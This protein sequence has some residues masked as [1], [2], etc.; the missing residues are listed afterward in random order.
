MLEMVERGAHDYDRWEQQVARTGYCSK[1][2]R[3]AGKVQQVDR[4]TGEIRT[5]FDSEGE[6][7]NTLLIACGDRRESRCPSCAARYRGDAFHIVASG[8]KGGKGVPESVT[9]HPSLFVTFTAPSFG[10]VHAHRS[11]GRV[12]H[13][14]RPRRAG[15]CPHGQPLACWQRHE[16]GDPRVG[17]PL[18]PRCF[19]YEGQ[20]LWNNRLPE[21]WSRTPLAIRRA[22]AELTS[23]TTREVEKTIKLSFAKSA[24][25]QRRG[26]LH[27]HV[28]MR[29]D[30]VAQG[31]HFAP[32]P[33][34]FTS[35]AFVEAVQRAAPHV[36]VACPMPGEGSAQVRW[37]EQLE[38]RVIEGSAETSREAVSAYIA[39]YSTKSVEAFGVMEPDELRQ[40]EAGHL[41]RLKTVTEDLS[42][43]PELRHLGLARGVDQVGFKGHWT[44]KS[45]SY[46]TT[47]GALR[48]A[49]RMHV[50]RKRVP[51]GV[52]LDAWGR[53]EE[54]DQAMTYGVWRYV[55]CGYRNAGEAFL[56]SSAAAR[57]R[58]KRRV[59]ME[60][61]RSLPR[62]APAKAPVDAGR[63]PSNSEA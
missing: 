26:A 40:E 36:R 4:T 28:V 9:A 30:G 2:V 35:E 51:H 60:E 52:P 17:Q 8:L 43:L 27:F 61:L 31:E 63:S 24:E 58:E 62:I 45:R 57:A 53:P 20:V 56:A 49:R 39:K 23:M 22:L 33:E 15:K 48:A 38:V 46:S 11:S 50:K 32:P 42:G 59:A 29:L 12:I 18:C 10:P 13:P 19:D 21:L 37:G 14:C 55:A 1:P 44:T 41:R 34:Q 47:F 54:D 5:T 25:F 7:N 6:P 16:D 3:L